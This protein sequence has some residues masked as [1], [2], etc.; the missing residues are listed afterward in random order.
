MR[1]EKTARPSRAHFEESPFGSPVHLPH[2]TGQEPG[3]LPEDP[4]Q[5]RERAGIDHSRHGFKAFPR[6]QYHP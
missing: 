3:G 1:E 5:D 2:G 4:F 6:L